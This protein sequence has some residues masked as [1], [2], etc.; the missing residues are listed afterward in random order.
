MC[1]FGTASYPY[2]LL[3]VLAGLSG[4]GTRGFILSPSAV[5]ALVLVWSLDT[6]VV[7][8]LSK[9][10]LGE[11]LLLQ[12]ANSKSKPATGKKLFAGFICSV[13]S[14]RRAYPGAVLLRRGQLSMPTFVLQL[15]LLP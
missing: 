10:L 9:L 3:S 2:H 13:T 4:T 12:A 14:I 8:L 1:S 6:T 15:Y 5:S 7:S 11:V